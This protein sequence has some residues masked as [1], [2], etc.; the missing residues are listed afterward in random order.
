[1]TEQTDASTELTTAVATWWR[2]INDFTTLLEELDAADWSRPT[3]LAGW[4]VHD[5]AAHTAHLESLLVGA[6]HAEVELGDTAH[7]KSPMGTFTEQGVVA[8]RGASPDELIN[9]IRESATSR[10]TAL[11]ADPPTDPDAVAPGLFGAIGW[12]VRTLL[13]NRPLDVWMH[14][15][16]VRRA[17]GRPGNLDSPAARHSAEY[18]SESLGFVLAKKV[19]A[20]VDTT[21]ALQVDGLPPRVACVAPDGRGRLLADA[22]ATD[23]VDAT[24]QCDLE[25]FL[26]LAGGR[27]PPSPAWSGQRR[28]RPGPPGGRALAVTP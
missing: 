5:V 9:E 25:S 14:E 13:R 15:Q 12:S 4:D 21:V 10:N 16:D 2:A 20:P 1:M 6:P 3:D 7:V 24:I 11:L 22:P 28:H 23:E 19:R 27:R 8:R 17:V 18:L 26:L